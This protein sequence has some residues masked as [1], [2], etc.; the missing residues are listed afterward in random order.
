VN[1]FRTRIG[2]VLVPKKKWA[3]G[4]QHIKV[5]QENGEMARAVFMYEYAQYEWRNGE[6]VVWMR[7]SRAA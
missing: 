2:A 1:V 7:F 4:V 3:V 6:H 5:V